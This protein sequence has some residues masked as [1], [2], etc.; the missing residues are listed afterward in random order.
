MKLS[1]LASR[2]IAVLLILAAL[3]GMALSIGGLVGVQKARPRLQAWGVRQIALTGDALQSLDEALSLAEN[4]LA[5][6]SASITE[7][8]RALATGA[9][10]LKDAQPTLDEFKTL[11]DESIPETVQDTQAALYAAQADARLIEDTLQALTAIPFMPG[12]PYQPQKSMS[13]SL[14]QIAYTL[15]GISDS[16]AR[17]SSDLDIT[18]S[19]L[20]L[21]QVNLI[22]ISLQLDDIQKTLGDIRQALPRY[23]ALL[24]RTRERVRY[25]SD[26][27]GTWLR[28][29]A[30]A[31]DA[32][33][34]WL[35]LTQGGLLL[36]G[37]DWWR[38][39]APAV[40]ASR[41]NDD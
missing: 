29:A 24:D 35:F 31:L 18:K 19:N 38:R 34:V 3:S 16:T 32:L 21:V 5:A 1:P 14:G 37:L 2:I 27:L 13:E 4:A 36:Q 6:A 40:E 20:A 12:E 10:T 39:G 30:A 9:D 17:I 23:R 33:F 25:V 28:L 41:Q 15:G 8:N 11:L 7:L 26:A 22:S